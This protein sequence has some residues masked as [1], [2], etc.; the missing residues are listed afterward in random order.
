[1]ASRE[2]KLR[3]WVAKQLHDPNVQIDSIVPDASYRNYYR[4]QKG[5]LS[6]IAVDADPKKENN[7]A[8]VQIASVFAKQGLLVPTIYAKDLDHGFMLLTDFGDKLLFSA[9]TSVEDADVYYHQ[10]FDILVPLNQCHPPQDQ[11]LPLFD[12]QFILMELGNFN[13]W[14]LEKLLDI[15]FSDSINQVLQVAYSLL[16]S[17]AQSQ[18]QVVIH[19]DFHS[20]N[21]MVLPDGELG[22]IDFQDAM[23]GPITYDLVSLLKDCYVNWPQLKVD[24]WMNSFHSLAISSSLIPKVPLSQFKIWFDW[25]GLQRHLKVM[26]I[27]SR[28]KIRDNKPQYISQMPRIMDYVLQVTKEYEE[29]NDFNKLLIDVIVPRLQ[30]HWHDDGIQYAESAA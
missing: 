18:V 12:E 3:S 20:R 28:L 16:I 2:K 17:S 23:L 5:K 24:D 9:L 25:M 27:F 30:K 21:L 1:M 10:A 11:S 7:L 4:V 14:C 8:F 22:I 13:E 15:S 19:R 26:G 6:Y 29:F